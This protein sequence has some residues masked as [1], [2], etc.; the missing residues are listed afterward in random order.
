MKGSNVI[1]TG[2]GILAIMFMSG[3]ASP[4]IHKTMGLRYKYPA[5]SPDKVEV[6]ERGDLVTKNRQVIGNVVV[7]GKFGIS[8]GKAITLMKQTAAEM[9][10][11]GLIDVHKGPGCKWRYDGGMHYS[12]IAVKWLAPG[13]SRQPLDNP[14][15]IYRLPVRDPDEPEEYLFTKNTLGESYPMA[16]FPWVNRA[17]F[18]GYH[19]LPTNDTT[20]DVPL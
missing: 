17:V 16:D 7:D 4:V 19:V 8:K 15:V 18:K 10:A 2:L 14:F 3:C 1:G 9:G 12:G 5:A 6:V 20:H 13:Q 11:N